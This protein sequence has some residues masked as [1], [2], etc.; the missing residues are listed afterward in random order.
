V[1]ALTAAA[2]ANPADRLR[3]LD[4]AHSIMEAKGNVAELGRLE[5]LAAELV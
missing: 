1:A 3:L 2:E 5:L 4:D